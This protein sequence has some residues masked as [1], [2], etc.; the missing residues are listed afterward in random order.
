MDR[1]IEYWFDPKNERVWFT[2]TELDDRTITTK[3]GYLID[4]DYEPE[5]IETN[6][7]YLLAATILYDQV[8][9]HMHRF[10][11][12]EYPHI[13]L[14]KAMLYASR[15][16]TLFQT[17]ALTEYYE[18]KHIP[19]ILLPYR[20]TKKTSNIAY[21]MKLAY[22]IYKKTQSSY[23]RRFYQASVR[24]LSKKYTAKLHS[25]ELSTAHI[26]QIKEIL[27]PH[28]TQILAAP[29]QTRRHELLSTLEANLPLTS[30]SPEYHLIL[31]VSGGKDSMALATALKRLQEKHNYVL[32]AVHINYR[33]RDTSNAEEYLVTRYV[34]ETLSIPLYVRRIDEIQRSRTSA[35]R[36]F[37]EKL[38][39]EIRFR[40]YREVIATFPTI[41]AYVVLGHNHDDTVE[42]IV[43]NI[44]KK[45]SYENLLGMKTLSTQQGVQLLRPLLT[46]P[47]TQ[48]EDYNEKTSTPFTYD[49]TPSWSDRGRI[50]DALV[51]AMT[52]FTPAL[53][54]GLTH[55]S[56]TLTNLTATYE[57]YTL[58]SI[59]EHKV[60]VSSTKAIIEYDE[61]TMSEKVFRDI[62]EHLKIPH[63]PSTKSFKHFIEQLNTPIKQSKQ[64]RELLLTRDFKVIV[65]N[66]TATEPIKIDVPLTLA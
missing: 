29:K 33:N 46:L 18:P 6:P 15:I 23:L 39:K 65:H 54:T 8:S 10:F 64:K 7:K 13:H 41:P 2:P 27:D 37:Y 34:A 11:K 52:D 4:K 49:S 48:I 26:S 31:S 62:F 47:K 63:K 12:T 57:R 32:S 56:K 44:V 59:L 45:R 35:D 66:K 50:R 3:F 61:E 20:H 28:S 55:L 38:T 5:D 14:E 40:T 60:T 1:L 22:S 58:P 16:L 42:N 24:D 25:H 21:V 9:R 17:P 30:A 36:E 19:F 43:T 53:L 51:P